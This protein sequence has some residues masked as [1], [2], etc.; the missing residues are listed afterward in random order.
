MNLETGPMRVLVCVVSTKRG[1]V[2]VRMFQF[3]SSIRYKKIQIS[4]GV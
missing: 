3:G 1:R 4:A 2:F